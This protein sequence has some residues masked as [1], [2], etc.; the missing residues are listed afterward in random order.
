VL[1]DV[2]YMPNLFFCMFVERCSTHI[3]YS[4]C[5]VVFSSSPPV[6]YHVTCFIWL[7][8]LYFSFLLLVGCVTQKFWPQQ[9]TCLYGIW[10]PYGCDYEWVLT[11]F[12]SVMLCSMVQVQQ[13]FEGTH[14]LHLKV[15]EW[16]KQVA[17]KSWQQACATLQPY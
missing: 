11:L 16:P 1:W 8:T 15:E 13:H 6:Y 4:P 9:L 7:C 12:W 5:F 10:G 2:I 14:C 3:T 17:T